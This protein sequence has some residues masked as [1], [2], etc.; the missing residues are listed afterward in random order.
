M[1]P[2]RL[3][4][5]TGDDALGLEIELNSLGPPAGFGP[6]RKESGREMRH[7]GREH[8]SLS[9]TWRLGWEDLQECR[10]HGLSFIHISNGDAPSPA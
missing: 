9:K 3:G 8:L 5:L 6:A 2:Q 7:H 4:V 10:P 1:P